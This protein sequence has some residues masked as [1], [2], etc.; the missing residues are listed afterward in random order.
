MVVD[1]AYRLHHRVDRRRADNSKAAALFP[2]RGFPGAHGSE[3]RNGGRNVEISANDFAGN[4]S[5]A[6]LNGEAYDIQ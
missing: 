6:T 2:S 1:H 5:T 3:V 4:A